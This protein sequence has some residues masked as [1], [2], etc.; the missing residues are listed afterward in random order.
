MAICFCALQNS[1][2]LAGVKIETAEIYQRATNEFLAATLF[3]PAELKTNDLT[4]TLAPL[5]IQEHLLPSALLHPPSTRNH[6][7]PQP[8]TV[9][10]Y[11]PDTVQLNGN[12]MPA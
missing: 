4:F 9:S 10:S 3:K 1:N 6:P 11:N 2:L 5:I 8:S 12:L 7:V